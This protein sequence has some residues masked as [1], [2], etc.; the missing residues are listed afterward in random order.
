VIHVW[1][2][3]DISPWLKVRRE[4]LRAMGP[5]RP[6][7]ILSYISSARFFCLR[8]WTGL[9]RVCWPTH[10]TPLCSLAPDTAY[11]YRCF[12]ATSSRPRASHEMLPS[13]STAFRHAT[14]LKHRGLKHCSRIAGVRTMGPFTRELRLDML[15]E[16]DLLGVTE[17]SR[18]HPISM[19]RCDARSFSK[20]GHEQ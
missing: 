10:W 15:E 18:E 4:E 11:C 2:V 5:Q 12:L 20:N 1:K 7:P 17:L 3:F 14:H 9:T 16:S 6:T 8:S 19:E 13:F